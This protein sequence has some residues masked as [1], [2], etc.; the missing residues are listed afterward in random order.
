LAGA[1]FIEDFGKLKPAPAFSRLK[2]KDIFIK[3]KI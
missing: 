1:H 3:G 2:I